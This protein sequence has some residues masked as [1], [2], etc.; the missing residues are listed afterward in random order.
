MKIGRISDCSIKGN[1]ARYTKRCEMCMDN[2]RNEVVIEHLRTAR[3]A[4]RVY[5]NRFSISDSNQCNS[6][7]ANKKNRAHTD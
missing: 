3:A 2:R 5:L 1:F 4:T 6:C 7:G